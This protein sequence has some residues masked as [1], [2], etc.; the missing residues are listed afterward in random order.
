MGMIS[1]ITS[2][3]TTLLSVLKSTGTGANLSISNSSTLLFKLLKLVGKFFNLSISNLD[4]V[5]SNYLFASGN[6]DN[7]KLKHLFHDSKIAQSYRQGEMKINYVIQF[8]IAPVCE[9]T[10]D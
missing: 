4:C 7:E 3:F 8:G 10:D 2:Y 1:L 5:Q 9:G 6:N